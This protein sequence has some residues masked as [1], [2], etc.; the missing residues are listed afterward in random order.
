MNHVFVRD[1]LR[2]KKRRRMIWFVLGSILALLIIGVAVGV[3][4][5]LKLSENSPSATSDTSSV[6]SG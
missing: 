1:D 3:P 6:S 4:V 5:G 2:K